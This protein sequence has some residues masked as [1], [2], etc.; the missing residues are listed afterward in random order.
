[1][2]SD[3]NPSGICACHVE[4]LARDYRYNSESSGVLVASTVYGTACFGEQRRCWERAAG[5]RPSPDAVLLVIDVPHCEQ[6]PAPRPKQGGIPGNDGRIYQR[7]GW[8]KLGDG[9]DNRC[10]RLIASPANGDAE[11]LFWVPPDRAKK[12]LK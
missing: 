12:E 2:N 9:I 6:C 7:A 4:R 10:R 3:A 5:D 11:G 1:M 8:V